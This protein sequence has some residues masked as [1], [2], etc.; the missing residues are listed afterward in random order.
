MEIVNN[1]SEPAATGNLLLP[2]FSAFST[3][4]VQDGSFDAILFGNRP[5]R[6]PPA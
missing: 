5:R 1:T 2:F 3:R 4:V 6:V